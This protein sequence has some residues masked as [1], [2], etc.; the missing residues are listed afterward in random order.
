[1]QVPCVARR[2]GEGQRGSGKASQS[3]DVHFCTVRK[4]TEDRAL[5]M[6]ASGTC[7]RAK[8]FWDDEL[9]NQY[10]QPIVPYTLRPGQDGG[11]VWTSST[12]A[13]RADVKDSPDST[14]KWGHSP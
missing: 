3:P 1:M 10:G 14:T 9:T 7:V 5:H 13:S 12:D 2:V 6:C 4:I 8:I 11:R